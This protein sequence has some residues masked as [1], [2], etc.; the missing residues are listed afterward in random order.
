MSEYGGK[1]W[2]KTEFIN[3]LLFYLYEKG[4]INIY[5]RDWYY[6]SVGWPNLAD[7]LVKLGL[8]GYVPIIRRLVDI[9]AKDFSLLISRELDEIDWGVG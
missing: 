1:V 4:C 3:E 7:K 9:D 8:G 6:N 2:T 5:N